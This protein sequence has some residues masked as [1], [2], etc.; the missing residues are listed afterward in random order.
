LCKDSCEAWGLEALAENAA[1]EG[2]SRAF[3]PGFSKA[4]EK[5]RRDFS[6][7]R[8]QFETSWE[9]DWISIGGLPFH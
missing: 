6:Q 9:R 2:F 8:F 1:A 4:R 5:H 3:G 7:P